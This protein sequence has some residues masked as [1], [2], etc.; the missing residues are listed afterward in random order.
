VTFF[1]GNIAIGSA[2][3]KSGVA[4]LTTTSLPTGLPSITAEYGGNAT[5]A[6]S[7]SPAVVVE[8]N[9]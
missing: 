3:L 4:V 1:H 5:E 9:P 7:G 6:V 2:T 8:V